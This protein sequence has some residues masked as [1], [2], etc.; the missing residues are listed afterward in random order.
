MVLNIDRVAIVYA[1]KEPG[2]KQSWWIYSTPTSRKEKL[3]SV[4]LYPAMPENHSTALSTSIDAAAATFM[5]ASQ[6]KTQ[7]ERV[8]MCGQSLNRPVR[9]PGSEKH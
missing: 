3:P 4:I 8:N 5:C 9:A 2:Q 6:S 7:L 1:S